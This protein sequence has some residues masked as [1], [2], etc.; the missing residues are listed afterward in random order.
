MRV[1]QVEEIYQE[2]LLKEYPVPGTQEKHLNGCATAFLLVGHMEVTKRGEVFRKLL[3]S[4]V[5]TDF[6]YDINKCVRENL[7]MPMRK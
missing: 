1:D 7:L 3:T 6:I 4:K 2:S 5:A